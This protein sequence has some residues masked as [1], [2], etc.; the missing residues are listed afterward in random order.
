MKNAYLLDTNHVSAAINPVSRLRERLN[1]AHRR[2][3]RLATSVPVLCELEAGIQNSPHEQS[4][5]RH[6]THVLR[7]VRLWPIEAETARIYGALFGQLRRAGRIWSQVDMML[8][9]MVLHRDVILLT[10]D[11]D[12]EALPQV[13]TENWLTPPTLPNSN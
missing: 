8:A 1:E 2:G 13:R 6:L 7:R 12:F 4:Y 10:S 5:R 9:A 11:R 3:I